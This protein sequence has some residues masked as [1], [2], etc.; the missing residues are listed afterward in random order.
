MIVV[1]DAS[2]AIKWYVQ[3][4]HDQEAELLLTEGFE[5]HAPEL[6]LPEFGN[7]VWK[8]SRSGK[9]TVDEASTIVGRFLNT[10]VICHPQSPLLK[11]AIKLAMEA[12]QS[13]YD[14]TYL[15]LAISLSCPFVTADK[16]FYKA[17]QTTNY[18]KHIFWI[19]DVSQLV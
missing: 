6:L 2:V 8:K 5:M 19:E 12:D 18:N 17:I 9:L 3:E 4:V 11:T 10:A 7:I 1:V 15:T 14:C 16:R 13:V